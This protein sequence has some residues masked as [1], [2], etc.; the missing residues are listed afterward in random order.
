MV[1]FFCSTCDA[2]KEVVIEPLKSD[3]L[4]KGK[5]PWGDIVCVDCHLVIATISAKQPGIYRFEREVTD[6]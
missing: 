6:D 5:D 4:N 2:N 1:R 3:D